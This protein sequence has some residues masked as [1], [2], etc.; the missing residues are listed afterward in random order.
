MNMNRRYVSIII[1]LKIRDLE[2]KIQEFLD[3]ERFYKKEI[4][5]LQE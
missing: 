4:S 2:Q 5:N 3:S 1:S